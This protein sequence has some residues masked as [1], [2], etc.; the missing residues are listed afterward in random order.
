MQQRV[1]RQAGGR[2]VCAVVLGQI[3]AKGGFVDVRAGGA[4]NGHHIRIH[5]ATALEHALQFF[6]GGH[7][8]L[9]SPLLDPDA[10]LLVQVGFGQAIGYGHHHHQPGVR[11]YVFGD[12]VNG[13]AHMLAAGVA[14]HLVEVANVSGAQ[15]G[16][17]AVVVHADEQGTAAAVGKGGQLGGQ[18]VGVVEVALELLAGVFAQRNALQQRGFR[19][20]GLIHRH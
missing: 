3:T 19:Q 5:E 10:A 18:G 1:Q 17:A 11:E 9:V 8:A 13:R 12:G 4:C 7:M 6:A 2:G 15:P 16:D 20:R 14:E